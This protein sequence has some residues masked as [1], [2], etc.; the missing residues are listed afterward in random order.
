MKR[1]FCVLLAV[2]ILITTILPVMAAD[3]EQAISPRYSYIEGL[4]ASLAIGKLGL[5]TCNAAC[6]AYGGGTIKLTSVLQRYNGSSWSTVKAWT[7][8]T[9]HTS[10]A[11]SK[12]YAVTSGYTYRVR[13]SCGVYNANGT[14]VE[15]GYIYSNQVVY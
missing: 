8:S 14:L 15:S 4:S 12:Q 2:L 1:L 5:S 11:L 9:T 3:N 13:A 7:T 10:T 6:V